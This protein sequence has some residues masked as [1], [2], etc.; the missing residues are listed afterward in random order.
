MKK[1]ILFAF[2]F[3][4]EFIIAQKL[5]DITPVQAEAPKNDTLIYD[6]KGLEVEPEFQGGIQKF[7]EFFYSNF[8]MPME[9]IKGKIVVIFIIEKDGSLSNIKVLRGLGLEKEVKQI[10][11]MAPKWNPGM[12][13]G[14]LVRTLY[15]VDFPIDNGKKREPIKNKKN[16][17]L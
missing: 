10:L 9:G 7:N 3:S 12:Q 4:A 6:R 17:T 16:K 15:A 8:K 11:K 14:K 5:I 13:N 2:L 1:I